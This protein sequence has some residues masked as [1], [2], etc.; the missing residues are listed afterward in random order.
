MITSAVTSPG[1]HWPTSIQ[2]WMIKSCPSISP[3]QTQGLVLSITKDT[4]FLFSFLCKNRTSLGMGK[5]IQENKKRNQ[6]FH[7][8]YTSTEKKKKRTNALDGE[9]PGRKIVPKT[10]PNASGFPRLFLDL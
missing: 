1:T 3:K 9:F 8:K 10:E 6:S 7:D 5:K 2:D 4:F